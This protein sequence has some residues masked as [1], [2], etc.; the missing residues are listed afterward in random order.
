MRQL[1]NLAKL[2]ANSPK[3]NAISQLN[4]PFVFIQLSPLVVVLDQV[5]TGHVF[6]ATLDGTLL[7]L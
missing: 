1:R 3:F 7:A 6:L 5:K 2:L 4:Y